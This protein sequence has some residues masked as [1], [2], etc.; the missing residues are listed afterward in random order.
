[1]MAPTTSGRKRSAPS[2]AVGIVPAQRF[3]RALDH[4]SPVA[5]PWAYGLTG[6]ASAA[7]SPLA[8]VP[9]IRSGSL[10]ARLYGLDRCTAA[11]VAIASIGRREG[12]PIRGEESQKEYHPGDCGSGS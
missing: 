2:A 8:I 1:M 12:T 5:V 9:G 10:A 6:S 3:L 11:V 4:R 7:G